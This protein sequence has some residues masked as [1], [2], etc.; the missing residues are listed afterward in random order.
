VGREYSIPFVPSE[1][2]REAAVRVEGR[3]R[4]PSLRTNGRRAC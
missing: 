2:G 1:H 4:E 3:V